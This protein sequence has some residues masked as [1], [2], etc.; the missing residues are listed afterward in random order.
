MNVAITAL[1]HD[2]NTNIENEK[3]FWRYDTLLHTLSYNFS[4][5][6]KEEIVRVFR[7]QERLIFDNRTQMN[8][9]NQDFKYT[10]FLR[11]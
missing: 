4:L 11:K 6:V 5:H 10:E 9:D 3:F 1:V 2:L 8:A 7:F